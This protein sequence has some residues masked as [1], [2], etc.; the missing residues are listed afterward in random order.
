MDKQLRDLAFSIT[1]T[2]SVSKNQINNLINALSTEDLRKLLKY[3]K[4]AQKSNTITVTAAS[5]DKDLKAL[6]SKQF[7]SKQINY[8]VDDT[9]GGG[10]IVKIGDDVYDYS[11]KNY[12][13]TTINR[14]S[15]EL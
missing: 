4:L 8:Q 7:D 15:E 10:V 11:V 13:N 3:L 12:I 2:D 5:D 9:I 6:V 1:K 14:L